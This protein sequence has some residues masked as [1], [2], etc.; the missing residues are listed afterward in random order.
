MSQYF[1]KPY[2]RFGENVKVELDLSN[3]ATKA[4]LKG[5]TSIDTSTLAS[6]TYLASLKTKVY[7]LYVD[8]LIRRHAAKTV[9]AYLNKLSNVVHNDIVK[10]NVYD[11]LVTKA[12][13]IDNRIQRTSRLF[14]KT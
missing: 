6:K 10:K 9:P 3:H 1:P 13:A 14:T 8:K 5:A 4:D 2:E 11:K 7:D 12:N